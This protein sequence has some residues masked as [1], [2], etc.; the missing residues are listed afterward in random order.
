MPAPF[1]TVSIGHTNVAT[2]EREHE[3]E[4]PRFGLGVWQM[5]EGGEC[6]TAVQHAIQSGYRLIDTARSYANETETGAAIR[7]SGIPRDEIF[8]VTKLRR[9]H[10]TSYEAA[11]E[12]CRSSLDMLGLEQ[13]DLYLVHAPPEDIDARPGV[14][15]GMEECLARGWTRAI[16]VSNYGAHH[17]DDM[18]AYATILPAVNQVELHPWNQRPALRAA[19][20]AS[21]ARV[22][23]YSPL[24]RGQKVN[25]G[26]LAAIAESVGC[27]PAQ[28]AIKWV[29]DTGAI[30][31]PKSSNPGRIE[32][33]LASL[34]IDLT[35]TEDSFNVMEEAYVSGWN[36]TAEA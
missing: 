27:T 24:A 1:E 21:G 9:P 28:A 31:I 4:M 6:R 33:N 10:A 36:P 26:S 16:G 8:V 7:E 25:C 14:W 15:K 2:G 34:D 30:T 18:R 22:M 20:K 12:H 32:E 3:I 23:A 5:S 17:L 13:L 19:T 11:L 35:G 29:Y